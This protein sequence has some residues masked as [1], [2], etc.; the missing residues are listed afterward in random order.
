[1]LK[2]ESSYEFELR[3]FLS[4]KTKASYKQLL[5]KFDINSLST[6]LRLS[7]LSEGF[8]IF[9]SIIMSLEEIEIVRNTGKTTIQYR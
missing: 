2:D 3:D 5:R 9:M 4:E 7:L 6:I 1:V 8:F